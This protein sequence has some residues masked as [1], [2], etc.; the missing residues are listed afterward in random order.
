MGV[1]QAKAHSSAGSPKG[2]NCPGNQSTDHQVPKGRE[3]Q[4]CCGALAAPT[5]KILLPAPQLMGSCWHGLP[6]CKGK[7]L[8]DAGWR[9]WGA[10]EEGKHPFR[11][12]VAEGRAAPAKP[13]AQVLGQGS[14]G[15]SKVEQNFSFQGAGG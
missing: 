6:L 2:L 14:L 11:L 8:R 15:S 13:E 7:Q 5:P 10:W 4:L 3:R 12:G 9:D 1:L